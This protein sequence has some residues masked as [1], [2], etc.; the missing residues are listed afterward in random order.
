MNKQRF[1]KENYKHIK[2]LHLTQ[3]NPQFHTGGTNYQTPPE[4]GRLHPAPQRAP[5]V[6]ELPGTSLLLLDSSPLLH[7]KNLPLSSN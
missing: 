5:P 2:I 7:P 4:E 6:L 1:I 3:D